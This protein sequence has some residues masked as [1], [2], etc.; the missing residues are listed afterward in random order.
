MFSQERIG[1]KPLTKL[2]FGDLKLNASWSAGLVYINVKGRPFAIAHLAFGSGMLSLKLNLE[3]V[4]VTV[5]GARL[6]KEDLLDLLRRIEANPLEIAKEY[7]KR[8][9]I[10]CVCGAELT[11]EESVQLGIGPICGGRM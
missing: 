5:N 7:G 11:N 8:T 1:K 6:R 10:C 3:A 9:G 4:A 2:V